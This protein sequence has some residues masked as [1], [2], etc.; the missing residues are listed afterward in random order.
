MASV[1]LAATVGDTPDQT[2]QTN[3]RVDAVK[4]VGSIAYIGGEFTALRPAGNAAGV[5]TVTRNHAAAIDLATG[6]LLPWNPNANDDVRAI[7]ASA[8]AVYL[9]G[10][11]TSVGGATAT[12][13]A[14]VDLTAGKRLTAWSGS[15]NDSVLALAISGSVVY[16][17]GKFTSAGGATAGRVAALSATSGKA[18]TGFSVS[19]DKVVKSLAV[20]P[21]K[22][23]L[24]VG[25]SFT[26]LNNVERGS[27]GSVNSA[28][29]SLQAW[30]PSFPYPVISVAASSD[31]VFVAGGGD[32]GNFVAFDPSSA[33][34]M[35]RGGTNG[36]AQ[37][38]TIVGGV[39][40]V[41]GHFTDYCGATVGAETCAKPTDRLKL[42]AVDASSGVLKPWNAR[43]NSTL[44]V[45]AL[46]GGGGA[47]VAGGDFTSIGSVKQQGVA[48]FGS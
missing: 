38:V 37:A 16:A 32:G 15:A 25:G 33:V 22:T 43:A 24:V 18:V 3:G 13:L 45:F 6:A 41:G 28:T 4:V 8:S 35:W 1:A 12:R 46:S 36:N 9:G 31:S 10:D 48:A 23:Q 2:W 30:D 34:V 19:A 44:G 47:L 5:G 27:V 29:G 21:G 42:L 7:T 11:F 26:R 17:G 40:Y 14:G 39:V 20:V